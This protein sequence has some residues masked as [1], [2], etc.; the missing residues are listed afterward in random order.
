MFEEVLHPVPN[1]VDCPHSN[2]LIK[3]CLP[4]S[5]RKIELARK[6][7]SVKRKAPVYRQGAWNNGIFFV[8]SGKVKETLQS[9]KDYEEIVGFARPGEAVGLRNFAG[10]AS[11]SVG[12]AAIE[13]SVLCFFDRITLTNLIDE[14]PG[15]SHNLIQRLALSLAEMD[16]KMRKMARLSLRQR[17]AASLL[18]LKDI[19]GFVE[20]K[21]ILAANLSRK[22]IAEMSGTAPE[23]VSRMLATFSKKG[24][25]S[26]HGREISLL[27]IPGIQAEVLV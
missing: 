22:E 2:C 6:I 9:G 13:E 1:C 8:F 25:V 23:V 16:R 3:A 12:A 5:K 15:L 17:V 7:L 20:G 24:L 11:T 14:C 18:E 21:N 4:E 10:T 27:D 26:L 19:F